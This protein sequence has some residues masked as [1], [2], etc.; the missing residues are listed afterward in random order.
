VILGAF[1]YPTGYHVAAWRHP[2]V[3]ADAGVNL[4]HYVELARTA[5]R[6]T[7]DFLFLPDSAAVRGTDVMALS[8]T[9]IRYV[10]QFE[11]MTLL[12]ALAAVTTRI[13]LT[14]T[15]S[16]TY[17]EPYSVAR[18]MASLDHLS[19]GR[20]GWN[21]VTSQ[22]PQEAFNFGYA[23][24]PDH[25]DRY[26][27]AEE[28]VDVVRGLWDS[29]S[30][31]AFSRNKAS[32]V[33]FDP[34]EY[35]PLDHKGEFFAVRGPLNIPRSP[36]GAPVLLQA[37]SS[38]AGRALAARTAE[39][40]FTAQPTM[41][42][43]QRFRADVLERAAA[44][45]RAPVVLAGVNPIVGP[46]HRAAQ[47]KFQELQDLIDPVVGLSL[48]ASELGGI[49][50]SGSDVDGPLPEL[51]VSNAGRSRQELLVAMARRENLTIRQL[52]Q[53]VSGSRGHWQL[54]GT[55]DEVTDELCRWVDSG[56]AD[57]FVVM[58]PRLPGSLDDFVDQVIPRLRERGRVR[59]DYRGSTLREQLGLPVPERGGTRG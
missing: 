22:N 26:R 1:L 6:G 41:E 3:P 34:A 54:T 51:P 42:G 49:D 45:G 13:G 27:R 38:P 28:F 4:G 5:E 58:P 55:P 9:A 47:A 23:A 7:M 20:A 35:R 24:Q 43:A 39:V 21:L 52:Y 40:V 14:A 19:G 48:L 31:G 16:S 37:G 25:A 17:N 29:W 10:A 32:G 59:A 8:R 57:G 46:T 2:D 12:G 50:L 53:R 44:F 36:Q 15:L 30:D 33:F 18:A 56:A 11:P